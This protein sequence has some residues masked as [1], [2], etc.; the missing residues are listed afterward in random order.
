M[1]EEKIKIKIQELQ[2]FEQNLQATSLQRQSFQVEINEIENALEEIKN[3]KDEVFKIVGNIMIKS[4]KEAINKDLS[5][6]KKILEAKIAAF[7]KQ[8]KLIE[9][10]AQKLREEVN[11][12]LKEK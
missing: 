7:E 9:E 2:I 4:E 11:E 6:K 3:T 10:K 8:E 1:D 12:F 5:E